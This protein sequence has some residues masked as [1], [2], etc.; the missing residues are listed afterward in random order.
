MNPKPIYK[1]I[2]WTH[3]LVWIVPLCM[4][5]AALLYGRE[6][7]RQRGP[8]ITID[9]SAGD[10]IKVGDTP[11]VYRGVQIGKVT[12][13]ELSR[14]HRK[15]LI[16]VRLERDQE[17]FAKEGAEFWVVRP[18]VS[19]AEFKGIDTIFTGPYLNSQPGSGRDKTEF[20]AL[21]N[22][23]GDFG[24]GLELS[25]HAPRLSHLEQRSPVYYRGIQVGIVREIRLG[26]E[27][28]R[29]EAHFTIWRRYAS[30]VRSHSKF[31]AVNGFDFK[32]GI[33]SGIDLKLQS[34]KALVSGGIAFATPDK[35]MGDPVKNGTDFA[36]EK[37]SKDEWMNW[38]PRIS[39]RPENSESETVVHELSRTESK[40]S[41]EMAGKATGR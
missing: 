16:R 12:E 26:N 41:G 39:I 37:E 30:L 33:F 17:S 9:V 21:S 31:W 7:L 19:A 15:A 40:S 4:G 29:V 20:S 38:A 2:H 36:L 5:V 32:G 13:I 25:V 14:D 10:G 11:L 28:D 3:R 22:A 24:E 8:V 27:A 35:D 18:E 23:P 6:F 34:V 1:K